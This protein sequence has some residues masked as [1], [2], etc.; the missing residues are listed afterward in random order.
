MVASKTLWND[1]DLRGGDDV[2]VIPVLCSVK[3]MVVFV[4]FNDFK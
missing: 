2:A 1:V 3:K 4:I